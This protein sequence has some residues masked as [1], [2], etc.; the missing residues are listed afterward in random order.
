MTLSSTPAI[1]KT[2]AAFR[3]GQSK[4]DYQ[5]PDNFIQA[6]TRRFGRLALDLAA[7]AENA[8]APSFYDTEQN[9]LLQP[10]HRYASEGLMW[11]N[12]PFNDVAPWAKKCS[13]ESKLGA[14][15]LFLVPASV[16]SNWFAH[17]VYRKARVF[18]LQGRLHFDQTHPGW[19]YPK[20]CLLAVYDTAQHGGFETWRW[21]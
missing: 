8:K 6:V 20:D 14:K 13:E 4:Q 10:W 3:R 11:L 7:T 21:R 2:G 5:T 15:I 19:G 9:A 12:P 1:T 17:H 16:G 18:F